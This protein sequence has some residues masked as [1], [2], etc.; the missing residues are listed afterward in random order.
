MA[1]KISLILF[2]CLFLRGLLFL[3]IIFLNGPDG[4]FIDF[5][6]P[7]QYWRIA[8]NL[9]NHGTFSRSESPPLKPEHGRPPHI[10]PVHRYS[11]DNRLKFV[12]NRYHSIANLF[13]DL[14]A[15]HDHGS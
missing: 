5:L 7:H 15:R 9:I 12:R 13:S 6:D 2:L 11:P 4:F 1:K 14:F 8:D 3:G 10:S